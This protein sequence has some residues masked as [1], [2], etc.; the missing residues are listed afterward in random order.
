[1]S[2]RLAISVHLLPTQEPQSSFSVNSSQHIKSASLGS[3]WPDCLGTGYA[4]PTL[5][6]QLSY[7]CCHMEFLLRNLGGVLRL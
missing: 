3:V 5:T 4:M 1:M 6:E 7:H 2:P